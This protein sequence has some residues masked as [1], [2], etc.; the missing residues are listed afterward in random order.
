MVQNA[1]EMAP[2]TPP[3]TTFGKTVTFGSFVFCGGCADVG[4]GFVTSVWGSLGIT[5]SVAGSTELL[6]SAGV[7][8]GPAPAFIRNICPRYA[9]I[10]TAPAATKARH[11]ELVSLRS[12]SRIHAPI[13]TWIT[14]RTN[15][16]PM[17]LQM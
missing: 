2:A 17:D 16:L 6:P 12:C 11:V 4:A 7:E 8:F 1:V 10:M 3:L 9:L 13:P 15:Q 14:L 5:H